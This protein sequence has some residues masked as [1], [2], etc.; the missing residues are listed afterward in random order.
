MLQLAV[1]GFKIVLRQTISF[2]S[3][4]WFR[5]V[6]SNPIGNVSV[7]SYWDLNEENQRHKT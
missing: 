4:M 6:A 5:S 7:G 3:K 2:D 1:F